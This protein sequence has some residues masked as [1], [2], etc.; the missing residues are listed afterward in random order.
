MSIFKSTFS[1]HVKDQLKVRQ[2]AIN[3]RTPQNLSY[4]NS[5]NAWI[6]MSSSVNVD[7][8]NDLAKKYILQGGTLN[9]NNNIND[10]TLK[11]G[12]GD[13]SKAYSNKSNSKVAYQRGIR[14]MPGITTMD[15][16]SKS[17]YG[18]LRE[19]TIHFQCWDIQQLEDIELLYMRPGYTVLVEW[20]WTP[21]LDN[22][23][24]YQPNFNDY[25]DI[26]NKEET[27][28]EIIFKDLY[29]KSIKYSGNYDAMFGYIKNYQWSARMD[30]GYD[31]TANIISTGE[32]I[33]SLKVNYSL[34]S[35]INAGNGLLAKEFSN[36]GVSLKWVK[37]YEKNSLAGIWAEAYSKLTGGKN[38]VL[39]A[40]NSVFINKFAVIPLSYA[41]KEPNDDK[42]LSD[43]KNQV[44][45]TLEAMCD[46]LNKY[47]IPKSPN[48]DEGKGLIELS[49]YSN[50]YDGSTKEPLYCVAHPLQ[51]SVDPSV[52]L[53]KSPLWYEN[54]KSS[55]ISTSV[56]LAAT[57]PDLIAAK[58]AFNLIQQS[59]KSKP[60]TVQFGVNPINSNGTG[61]KPAILAGVLFIKNINILNEVNNLI[62]ADSKS[63]GYSSLEALF[64]GEFKSGDAQYMLRIKDQLEK[65]EGV[66]VN[67]KIPLATPILE[68]GKWIIR[69]P[70]TDI[71]KAKTQQWQE[72][73]QQMPGHEGFDYPGPRQP[74]TVDLLSN[75]ANS[76]TQF[77]GG[78]DVV[79]NSIRITN[80]NLNVSSI[81]DIATIAEKGKQA[82]ANL[83]FLDQLNQFFY[84]A[85]DGSDELGVIKE[86]YVNV[87]FLYQQALSF[88]LE[89]KDNKEKGE[90]NLYNYLKS[91]IASIQSSIGNVNN[92]EIHVDPV[93][94][95][96]RIIDI[97]YT[98][99]SKDKSS[100]YKNL[101]EL[102]VH[103]LNS[104]VRSYSLQSQIFPD[105]SNLIAIGSQAKAKNGE[106]GQM[107]IQ[108]NTM[109][110]FNKNITDRIIPKKIMPKESSN[111][112]LDSN[113]FETPVTQTL[114]AII[115]E[116][117]SFS[118][119]SITTS[120][121]ADY[122]SLVATS[123]NALRDI[124]VYFQSLTK[125]PGKNRNLIPTKFSFEMDGVGGLVIGH[126]FKLPPN[127]MPKGYRGE[128]IGSQLGNAITSIGH[129]I[130]N[131]DW[132]TKVDTLN[133]V[134]EDTAGIEFK[135]I[136]LKIADIKETIQNTVASSEISGVKNYYPEKPTLP[137]A[138]TYIPQTQLAAYL[139]SKI[140]E[141][142]NKNVAIAVMAKS[143][144]EQGD[145]DQL[146][147]FNNNFYGVQTDSSRWKAQYD[148]YIVGT[149]N[150]KEGG[151]GIPRGFAAFSTPEIGA[152]FVISNIQARGIYIDGITTYITKGTRVTDVTTWVKIY[153][154]EWVKGSASAEPDAD[155]LRT[156][157][158]IYNKAVKLIG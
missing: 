100:V 23:G 115:N 150:L 19:V 114:A 78:V 17:A 72:T 143:I 141:G 139:K 126:M 15:I 60:T 42:T 54:G 108:S 116:F 119:T 95:K 87:D 94:N 67:F 50:E 27:K 26:I 58:Q 123:K 35:V 2:D 9:Y 8:T 145:G 1:K 129:T 96:A 122:G 153:Y 6:R 47:I 48:D 113:T 109:I 70:E 136:K 110:D 120:P 34:P 104:V 131:G 5:R 83:T 82:L 55:I 128:G 98:E 124:I 41:K 66:K 64:N 154:K 125:S 20:G 142:L 88:N 127:V 22:N 152:D 10:A 158:D 121:I 151:T 117:S 80:P 37:G 7:G 49:L 46:V 62:S 69:F 157:T 130:A 99:L 40:S 53:I 111:L 3:N 132:I 102:Q 146:R 18:S 81:E 144:S 61:R 79:S 148:D 91:I 118:T 43:G 101:F 14:P 59:Y 45:I 32:L 36:Q 12:L 103:N 4:M 30:G 11:S 106:G 156:R 76:I 56:D 68:D 31:C 155:F 13:F 112:N 33:E 25:Y 149:V 107:G 84:Q 24:K 90:I 97:N 85:A 105:Q 89:S 86:I 44:Y 39:L 137:F 63:S 134:L 140:K 16:K 147:G 71:D 52:C 77:S 29:D 135:Q 133:I 51:L 65:I 28:R 92:F 73:N 138:R 93:D 21:Y 38:G 74:I 57:N 75:R